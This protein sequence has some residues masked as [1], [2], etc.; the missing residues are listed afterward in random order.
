MDIV[1]RRHEVPYL[2]SGPPGTG[3]TKTLVEAVHQIL[4]HN[5]YASI[6]VCAPSNP[7]ADTLTRRLAKVLDHTT[8]F[9]LNAPTRTFAEVPDDLLSFC[10]IN[11]TSFGLPPVDR[12]LSFRVI[13][14]TCIDADILNQIRVNNWFSMGMEWEMHKKLHPRSHKVVPVFPHWTHLLIDEVNP[15][16]TGRTSS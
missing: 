4:E 14:S 16:K 15:L 8:L 5:P 10:E 9:R 6:L 13:I 12:L 2:I 7:A 11:G 1:N 3:K